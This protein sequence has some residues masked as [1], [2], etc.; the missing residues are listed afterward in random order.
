MKKTVLKVLC[1]FTLT[2]FVMSMSGA[3]ATTTQGGK[4]VE[5]TQLSQINKALQKGPVFLRLGADWCSHCKAFQPTLQ[6]LAKEYKGKVTVMSIDIDR[7]P[8][9]KNYFGANRIPDCSVIVSVKKGKYIYM[10]QNGKT[11]TDRSKARI[12]REHDIS[13][14][15][16]ILNFAIK[17]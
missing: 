1:I 3:A 5:I 2:L 11:T 16:K 4:V 17:K 7:S 8:K 13:V 14:Y 15:E 6:K 10:Q 12:I 9:L